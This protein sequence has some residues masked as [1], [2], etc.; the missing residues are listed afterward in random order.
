MKIGHFALASNGELK[1]TI[2]HHGARKELTLKPL[3]AA[4][5]PSHEILVSGRRTNPASHVWAANAGQFRARL[6]LNNG[7]NTSTSRYNQPAME[8]MQSIGSAPAPPKTAPHGLQS[9]PDD[10][11]PQTDN[12]DAYRLGS[13]MA[14]SRRSPP[15][16]T[17][18]YRSS[19]RLYIGQI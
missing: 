17:Q 16:G 13:D 4:A 10:P 9:A 15:R 5:G 6:A 18:P 1:G 3:A 12:H 14:D 11:S 7:A 19:S 2:D 8:A